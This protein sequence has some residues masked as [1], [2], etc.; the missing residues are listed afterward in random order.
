MRHLPVSSLRAIPALL[1]AL[2]WCVKADAETFRY[3]FTLNQTVPI[4]EYAVIGYS[5]WANEGE[6]FSCTDW[7]P[8]AGTIPY[9][10]TFTQSQMCQ[11]EEVRTGY[12]QNKSTFIE[13][14]SKSVRNER[15]GVGTLTSWYPYSAS[16]TDWTDARPLYDCSAWTP[17]ASTIM[18]SKVF[19]Q[20][21][22][23][24]Y[25][26]QERFRQEREQDAYSQTIRNNGEPVRESRT[27]SGQSATRRYTVSLDQWANSGGVKNCKN[28]SPS[29]STVLAGKSF[30]QTATDCQQTQ[31]RAR[32]ESYVDHISGD[33]VTLQDK[34]ET[35]TLSG[36]SSSRSNTGTGGLNNYPIV[37]ASTYMN[38]G[39][40][41]NGK[42]Y[43]NGGTGALV[44][45]PYSYN[46]QNHT[47]KLTIYGS[48]G[49]LAGAYYDVVSNSGNTVWAKGTLPSNMNGT[50][51]TRSITVGSV[52]TSLA[53]LEVRVVIQATSEVIRIDGWTLAP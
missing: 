35:Q 37:K 39:T 29:T 20:S 52:P 4:N 1:L 18:E 33:T 42:A 45:G 34:T 12:R 40:F 2:M 30:T 32:H 23:L 10:N 14:R 28:W 51:V 6:L 22:N 43:S 48:T 50:L 36:F 41:T 19:N 5:N 16:Y 26:D 21:S 13:K 27:L 38:T 9:G 8:S 25:T 31:T 15:Q 3:N 44:Y 11:Q 24:C 47:Y 49:A 7:S 53:G 17:A 46:A